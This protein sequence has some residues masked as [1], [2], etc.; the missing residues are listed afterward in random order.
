MT[1]CWTAP[2]ELDKTQIE[3]M[4]MVFDLLD[5]EVAEAESALNDLKPLLR[6]STAER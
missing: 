4:A 2:L 5:N 6:V 3:D 1:C